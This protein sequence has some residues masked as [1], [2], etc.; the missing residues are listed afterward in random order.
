M[1][2]EKENAAARRDVA[3]CWLD[4]LANLQIEIATFAEKPV[5]IETV[6]KLRIC[7]DQIRRDCPLAALGEKG[8]PPNDTPNDTGPPE[9][10][11][12]PAEPLAGLILRLPAAS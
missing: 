8:A 12:P 9:E 1:L 7:A 11:E 6:Q 5:P 4:V 3:T 2:N 10:M